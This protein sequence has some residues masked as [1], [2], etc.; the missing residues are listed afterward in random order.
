MSLSLS[1]TT[2][3]MAILGGENPGV[4]VGFNPKTGFVVSDRHTEQRSA[5]LRFSAASLSTGW[6][7]F[8]I[9]ATRT[10]DLKRSQGADPPFVGCTR[11]PCR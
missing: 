3:S 1:F 9:T 4:F 7:H 2:Q 5:D 11:S 6:H 8:V 10:R